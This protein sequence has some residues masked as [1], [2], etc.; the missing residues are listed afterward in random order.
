VERIVRQLR[1]EAAGGAGAAA[2]S[3][4]SSPVSIYSSDFNK[5]GLPPSPYEEAVKA[6]AKELCRYHT[7]G[8]SKQGVPR[9]RYP[10]FFPD[11]LGARGKYDIDSH[12]PYFILQQ[13]ARLA[14]TLPAED[15][16][17]RGDTLPFPTQDVLV[18]HLLAKVPQAEAAIKVVLPQSFDDYK[19][20]RAEELANLKE[21]ERKSRASRSPSFYDDLSPQDAYEMDDY[22]DDWYAVSD[23][24]YVKEPERK[25]ILFFESEHDVR[26]LES[27]LMKPSQRRY[28][29]IL[30]SFDPD[31]HAD[32]LLD[33][34]TP[35]LDRKEASALSKSLVARTIGLKNCR[36]AEMA[37]EEEEK[38]EDD[39]KLWG[40]VASH[41]EADSDEEDEEN[42]DEDDGRTVED[43]DDD[44]ED[45]DDSSDSSD[46]GNE[47]HPSPTTDGMTPEEYGD[48]YAR[49]YGAFM[50]MHGDIV[51]KEELDAMRKEATENRRKEQRGRGG[52]AGAGSAASAAR[53]TTRTLRLPGELGHAGTGSSSSSSSS[54]RG[55]RGRGRGRGGGGR[56]AGR[57]SRG[58]RSKN[59][60]NKKKK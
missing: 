14:R 12:V 44:D 60:P 57:G 50:R 10:R 47:Y 43:E 16:R 7:F 6:A 25:P 49:M 3:T 37:L 32:I 38:E 51:P 19:R 24:T 29:R 30:E 13:A 54:A 36:A 27:R 41:Q 39:N 5:L 23:N 20:E 40:P 8:L 15:F 35:W 34:H 11:L 46:G 18:K 52:G 53:A 4:L 31:E 55:G 48:W 33:P 26:L 58:G 17:V 9:L 1:L 42:D 56:G 21:Q 28:P 45:N 22:T 2:S 59:T